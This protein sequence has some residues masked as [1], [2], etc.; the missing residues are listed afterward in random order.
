MNGRQLK[1][2]LGLTQEDLAEIKKSVADAESRTS[3]EIALAVIAESDSYAVWEV[4]AAAVTSMVLFLCI[5]PLSPQIYQWLAGHFWGIEPWYLSLFFG[6]VCSFSV[7]VLYFLYNIPFIDSLV[8]PQAVKSKA[9]SAYA[10][11]YFA[12]SGVYCTDS[13][14]GVLVFVSLFEKQVRIVADKHIS[15]KVSSDLWNLIAD[16]IA[17]NI[18]K[19]NSKDAFLTA[20][21]KCGQLLAENFP[22]QSEK[23]N[24]LEDGL[25]ILE[26]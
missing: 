16:E 17:E 19:G 10:M 26:V 20:V 5:F 6:A 13:H 12:E 1:K 3:G 11:R 8:I 15:S 21:E 2:R 4:V 25:V 18:R 22:A 24:Q 9:V 7:I 23:K 14:S